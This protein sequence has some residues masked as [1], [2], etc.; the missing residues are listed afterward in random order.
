M[1]VPSPKISV[2]AVLA[3]LSLA[4]CAPQQSGSV[5]ASSEVMTEQQVE[6]GVLTGSRSVEL[7]NM[8]SADGTLGALAGGVAGAAAGQQVGGGTGRVLATGA[9]AVA[10]AALGQRAGQAMGR[11]QSIEWFVQLESGREISVIQGDPIFSTGQ[12]VRVISGGGSTR[13]APA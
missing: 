10:G 12:R 11:A 3:A 1:R 8:G 13:L 6:F 2:T 9:G 7:R 5:V 4:A